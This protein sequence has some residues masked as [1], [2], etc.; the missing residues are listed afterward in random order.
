MECD[1]EKEIKNSKKIGCTCGI[2]YKEEEKDG[3]LLKIPV[4]HSIK[5]GCPIHGKDKKEGDVNG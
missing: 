5:R 2:V 1:L 3:K 4:G